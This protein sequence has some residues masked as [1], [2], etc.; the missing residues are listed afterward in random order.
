ME[1]P[2][3][4][5]DVGGSHITCQI[6]D[7]Q[8]RKLIAGT[9]V[10]KQ[11]DCHA[12]ANQILDVW[13]KAISEAS[14]GFGFAN[15]C[16]IG[17]AMPGPFDY[18]NGI[19]WFRD[20]AK[21]DNLYGVNISDAIRQRLMI[22]ESY[23]VR[24]LNDA[25]CFAVG[26]SLMGNA[27]NHK[28]LLAITLGTGFGTTF[29]DNHIPVA[30]KYGIPE[31][32]FLYRVPFGSSVADDY[33]STRWFAN[34][35]KKQTGKTVSGVKELAEAANT[36]NIIAGLFQTFGNNLGSFLAPW[37]NS[38]D[39]GCLV[40]GGNIAASYHLFG[41]YL[42]DKLKSAGSRVEVLLSSLSEDAALTGSAMLCDNRF[43]SRLIDKNKDDSGL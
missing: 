4:G 5:C 27:V 18:Q 6:Y 26:G 23:P 11:V 25:A 21:Y 29:I 3:I 28:R 10:R 35:Y 41:P 1:K 9:R 8:N 38:F 20:V 17:F 12:P 40:I 15:I 31:D 16:G 2:A 32:G 42:S 22:P 34:E 7:G 39:A 37:L 14:S 13:A 19:A 24:F 43:Y 33:F 36:D 30:G